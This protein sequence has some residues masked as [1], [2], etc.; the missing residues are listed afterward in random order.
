M[1][2][3]PQGQG[4]VSRDNPATRKLRADLAYSANQGTEY[5][6]ITTQEAVQ[7]TLSELL[8]LETVARDQEA[9][10]KSL[11]ADVSHLRSRVRNLEP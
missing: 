7:E 8:R 9:T 5:A 10:N 3:T 11:V 4:G 2:S 6:V 1:N